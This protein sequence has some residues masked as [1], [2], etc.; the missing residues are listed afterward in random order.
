MRADL[1]PV[2]IDPVFIDQVLTNLLENAARHAPPGATIRVRAAAVDSDWV[3][4]TV[5]DDGPGVP[6]D[7]LA[8]LFE[9]FSRIP[10][11]GDGSRPGS[12]IGL[13]VVRGL[14]EAMGGRV[15]ART[16]ELGGL[17]VDVDLLAAPLPVEEGSDTAVAS[18][19]AP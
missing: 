12:G 18:E 8:H 1:P 15:A 6:T 2:A 19:A 5:E 16:G 11:P 9:K 3:R 13:A 7:A 4:V 14:V 17:A 10:R